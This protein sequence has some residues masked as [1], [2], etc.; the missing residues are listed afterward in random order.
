MVPFAPDGPVVTPAVRQ[1]KMLRS[2]AREV[3]SI[4][5]H[6]TGLGIAESYLPPASAWDQRVRCTD[7]ASLT[8]ALESASFRTEQGTPKTTD[9]VF[10][11]E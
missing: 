5:A 7:F 8:M 9:A 1:L 10:L 3:G 6:M 2:M 4:R 11:F